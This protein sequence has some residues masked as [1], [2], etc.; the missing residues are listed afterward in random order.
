MTKIQIEDIAK[1]RFLSDV[2][3][4]PGGGA[5]A[6]VV[7]NADMEENDYER[8][9][10]LYE[11]GE[12]RQLTGLGKES[13]FAWLDDHRLIFPAVRSA[14]EKKHAEEKDPFTAWYEID[15]RGGEARPF[16]TAPFPAQKIVPLDGTH[17]A[18][19][20]T[21][22]SS[23]PDLHLLTGEERAKLLK[24]RK[25]EK[26]YEVIDELPFWFNG[27]GFVSKRRTGLDRVGRL[28]HFIGIRP[29][30]HAGQRDIERRQRR[31]ADQRD[32]FQNV[33]G[34]ISEFHVIASFSPS[35]VRWRSFCLPRRS[36]CRNF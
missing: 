30:P 36:G 3:Y 18:V 22:D 13:G 16:F 19:M 4:A 26:D 9:I 29:A 12:I 6:F 2:Q 10:W 21:V 33:I 35:A 7:S 32:P 8:Y 23:C 5:A 17:F 24:E 28:G 25:E 31:D 1:Y 20:G 34:F 14:S 15:I 27:A 11:N